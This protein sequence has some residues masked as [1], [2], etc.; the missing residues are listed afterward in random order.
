MNANNFKKNKVFVTKLLFLGMKFIVIF[1]IVFVFQSNGKGLSQRVSF[2]FKDVSFEKI[3]NELF[4]I[5][6]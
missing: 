1:L 2:A 4:S 5:I 6:F 3:F